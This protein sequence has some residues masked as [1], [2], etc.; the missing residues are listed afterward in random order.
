MQTIGLIELLVTRQVYPGDSFGKSLFGVSM[1]ALEL[2]RG[3]D[4]YDRRGQLRALLRKMNAA[5]LT[6][7]GQGRIQANRLASNTAI[8]L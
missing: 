2:D 3:Y 8:N 7:D 4:T 1:T 5:N 6:S